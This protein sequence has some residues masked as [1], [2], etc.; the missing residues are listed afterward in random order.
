VIWL[1]IFA[2]LI[3]I[4]ELTSDERLAKIVTIAAI[5]ASVTTILAAASINRHTK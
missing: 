2:V 5:G 4:N 1:C 3:A